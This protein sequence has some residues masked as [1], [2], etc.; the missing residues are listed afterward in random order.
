MQ[1]EW[2]RKFKKY[3]VWFARNQETVIE[4]VLI[5]IYIGID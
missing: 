4:K 1:K 3:F 5:H 2:N